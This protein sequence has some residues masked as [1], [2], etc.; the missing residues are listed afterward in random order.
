MTIQGYRIRFAT[1]DLTQGIRGIWHQLLDVVGI[2]D[3]DLER[4]T[5]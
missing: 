3:V 4:A 2:G 5:A 1:V